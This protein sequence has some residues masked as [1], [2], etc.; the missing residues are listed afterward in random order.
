[1]PDKRGIRRRLRQLRRRNRTLREDNARLQRDLASAAG[2][3]RELQDRLLNEISECSRLR[4]AL[5]AAEE[6]PSARADRG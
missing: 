6:R 2:Y 3:A 4:G 1:M 5:E